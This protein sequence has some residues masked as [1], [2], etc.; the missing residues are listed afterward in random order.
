MRKIYLLLAVA[1]FCLYAASKDT[2][3]LQTKTAPTSKETG[4]IV[5]PKGKGAPEAAPS[6]DPG[7]KPYVASFGTYGSPRINEAV[8]K[9]VLGSDLD[10][11]IKKGLAGDPASMDMEKRFIQ[12]LKKKF[13]FAF[14]EWS[15]IQ[16]FEPG[17]LAL[18]MTLDVVEEKD[19]AR[20]MPFL[21]APTAELADPGGLIKEW[22]EYEATAFDLVEAGKLEPEA[23][24]C[25]ALHCPFGHKQELLKKWEKIFVEGVK[26]HATALVEVQAK[27]KRPEYRAA[28]SYL[29]AYWIDQK[30]KVV[31]AMIG[32]IKDPDSMVRNNALRVL[33]DIAEFHT[34]V[35]VPISP[36][37]PAFDFPRVSDRSKALYIATVLAP[38]SAE[39]RQE[40]A[41]TSVPELIAMIQTK[42]PDQHDLA[43]TLLKKV[44]GKDFPDTDIKAWTAWHKQAGAREISKK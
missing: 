2:L 29:L 18:H 3:P 10:V 15:I 8:L 32:R 38:N 37:L 34:E 6:A 41:R 39:V 36:V 4:S 42:Q 27:D 25:V 28:A 1:P 22:G 35:V 43:Y 31:E 26:K 30:K 20:R 11:W 24:R 33:G 44:S 17:A 14:A 23:D 5:A 19:A 7:P 40:I 16:F 13:G 12:K 21:P 9:E